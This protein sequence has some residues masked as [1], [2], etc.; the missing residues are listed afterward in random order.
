M[1]RKNKLFF[2]LL[3]LGIFG[4]TN[5]AFLK[6]EGNQNASMALIISLVLETIGIIGLFVVNFRKIRAFFS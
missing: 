4:I 6:L 2:L 3:L 1:S 5:S